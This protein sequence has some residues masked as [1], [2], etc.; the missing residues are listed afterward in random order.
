MMRVLHVTAGNLYGGV[1]TYLR[2]I[3]EC[4]HLC[5]DMEPEFAVCFKG[6]LR[7]ELVASGVRVHDLGPTRVSR[8]WTVLRARSRLRRVLSRG[9][10]DAVVCQMAW[11]LGLFGGIARRGGVVAAHL[12]GP[13]LGGWV[14]KLAARR[15]PD[16]IIAPSKH[17]VGTWRHL[18]PSTRAEALNNPLPPQMTDSQRLAIDRR[19]E[20]RSKFGA[21]HQDVI[22]LQASRMEAWKGPDLTLTALARL[23]DLPNWRLWLAGGA[24]RPEE[25]ELVRYLHR[26]TDELGIADRVTFL[27]QRSDIPDLMQSADIY[28]QGNR[29]PEGFSLSFLEA[30][31]SG[32]PVVTTDLGGAGEMVDGETGFL[33]PPGED[34]TQLASALRELITN[35]GLRAEMG[36]RAREKAIRL[37]EPKQQLARLARWLVEAAEAARLMC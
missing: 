37:C 13:P 5:P 1:E 24:Q 9:N 8:P 22:V 4:R 14:D 20:I 27:G 16:L 26:L 18:F 7:D 10:Y 36:I 6:R 30:S 21:S 3:A 11:S 35:P 32:L 28:C 23:R 15:H 2:T 34:V 31:Y 33:V 17:T 19:V 12:H 29:G 25:Q